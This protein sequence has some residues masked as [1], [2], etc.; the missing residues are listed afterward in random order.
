[1]AENGNSTGLVATVR[2]LVAD[3]VGPAALEGVDDGAPLF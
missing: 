1:L 3:V 2:A